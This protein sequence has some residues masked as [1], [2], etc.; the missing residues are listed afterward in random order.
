MPKRHILRDKNKG[1]D[2]SKALLYG[3]LIKLDLVIV[4]VTC[5]LGATVL[6]V[7][8]TSALFDSSLC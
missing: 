4:G 3:W 2:V 8:Y 6:P 1:N 7:T 5:I